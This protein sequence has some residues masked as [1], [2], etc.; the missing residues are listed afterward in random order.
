MAAAEAAALRTNSPK[1]VGYKP[2][3]MRLL[4]VKR[5]VFTCE[6]HVGGTRMLEAKVNVCWTR[7]YG[8]NCWRHQRVLTYRRRANKDRRGLGLEC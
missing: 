3:C 8:F 6:S 4:N 7:R 2:C 5:A 1:A